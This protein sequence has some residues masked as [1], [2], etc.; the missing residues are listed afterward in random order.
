M[1]SGSAGG[2]VEAE[3]GS[4][5]VGKEQ[6]GQPDRGQ[7][8]VGHR[9][10]VGADVPVGEVVG[11][12]DEERGGQG[13]P[14][15]HATGQPGQG[16]PP[17]RPAGARQSERGPP[18]HEHT[19]DEARLGKS[20]QDG[21]GQGHG[22]QSPAPRSTLPGRLDGPL[23]AQQTQG[24][25]GDR[26]DG[27]VGQPGERPAQGEG[28]PGRGGQRPAHTEPADQEV[29]GPA[30]DRLDD[31]LQDE[32]ALRDGQHQGEGEEGSALHLAGQW[33][34]DPF[35]RVPPGDVAVEPVQG[36]PVTERLQ[37]EAGVAVDVGEAG[38]PARRT[39]CQPGVQDQWI[40]GHQVEEGRTVGHQD[41]GGDPDQG[42]Q[43]RRPEPWLSIRPVPGQDHWSRFLSSNDHGPCPSLAA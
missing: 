36:G 19:V 40:G 10:V 23:H 14:D 7:R 4:E 1:V 35:V 30:G 9:P 34:A 5:R 31:Q 15:D 21:E 6:L 11:E 22:Q 12:G 38:Q 18:G 42:H 39:G 27:G 13:R 33:R 25:Q 29:G 20:G 28:H 8:G 43:V 26:S 17:D 37:G 2:E 16:G 41:G 24:E 3:D 32:R